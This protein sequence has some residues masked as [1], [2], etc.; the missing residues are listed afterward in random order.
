VPEGF[1]APLF[2]WYAGL[3][4]E[5]DI[6]RDTLSTHIELDVRDSGN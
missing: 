3:L 4:I 6:D 1:R 5:L 2:D